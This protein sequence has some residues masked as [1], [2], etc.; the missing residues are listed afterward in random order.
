MDL[1]VKNA[2]IKKK[3]KNE[4]FRFI[5]SQSDMKNNNEIWVGINDNDPAYKESVNQE[6]TELPIIDNLSDENSLELG[7]S[8]RDFLKYLGFGLGAATLAAG[9]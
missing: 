2:T 9:V 7:S 4:T 6:F 8:R 1:N 5:L 3:D